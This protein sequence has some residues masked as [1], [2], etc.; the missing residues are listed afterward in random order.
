MENLTSLFEGQH[1]LTPGERMAYVVGGL[2]LAAAG[3][4]P[5]PNPL[6]N[7]IALAGGAYFAYSGYKGHCPAKA[8]LLGP[9]QPNVGSISDRSSGPEG[10]IAKP[11]A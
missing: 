11:R 4:K 3:A 2:G 10:W 6:L 8:A 5:R 1:N 9:S 7:V